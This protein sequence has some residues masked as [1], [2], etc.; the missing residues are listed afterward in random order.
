[1]MTGASGN[2]HYRVKSP[3][4]LIQSDH[5]AAISRPNVTIGAYPRLARYRETL[6]A[7]PH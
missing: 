3:I 7:A 5:E 1:M 6:G 2:S 4:G